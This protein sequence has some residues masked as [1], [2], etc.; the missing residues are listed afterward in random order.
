MDRTIAVEVE[1]DAISTLEEHKNTRPSM[2]YHMLPTMVSD[3][4]PTLPS[5]RRSLN[6]A[7]NRATHSK[8]NSITELSQPE[9]P[10]PGYS[11]RPGSGCATPNR[12]SLAFAET[13]SDFS[14]DASER[15]SS[16]RSA[17]PPS[18]G[19]HETV[20]GINWKYASQGKAYPVAYTGCTM[21]TRYRQKPYDTSASRVKSPH[22]RSR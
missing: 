12:F 14:D 19:A 8:S 13:E 18:F 15:P 10:P 6:D 21:L 2:L 3:R 5:L 20:T 11:S 1:L 9:T 17:L 16:S 7:R 4:I 22:P